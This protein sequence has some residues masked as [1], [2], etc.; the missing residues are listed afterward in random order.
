MS[1]DALEALD[2]MLARGGDADD[3]LREIVRLLVSEPELVWAGIAF[4]EGDSLVLGPEAGEP[5]E[6]EGE[7]TRIPIVYDGSGVG[8]LWVDGHADED[9]LRLVAARVSPYVLVGW[10]V[11]GQ[12]WEP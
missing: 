3:L 2:R 11:Q 12:A 1:T 10:D 8:E 5:A 6:D 7:R 9:L 4:L